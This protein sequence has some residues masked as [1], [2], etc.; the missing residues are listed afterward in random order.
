MSTTAFSL[1][2]PIFFKSHSPNEN[3]LHISFKEPYP[4]FTVL[5]TS[6]FQNLYSNAK[7]KYPFRQLISLVRSRTISHLPSIK[8]IKI[9]AT[10]YKGKQMTTDEK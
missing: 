6:S 1:F 3:V 7:A 8:I 10:D 9:P 4:L 5:V 2:S